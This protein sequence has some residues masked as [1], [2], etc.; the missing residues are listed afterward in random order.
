MFWG[1][2]PRITACFTELVQGLVVTTNARTQ[3]ATLSYADLLASNIRRQPLL[4]LKAP[5]AKIMKEQ[6]ELVAAYADLRGD[7]AAEIM[8][9]LAP[10]LPF[11]GSVIGI[12]P[13]RNKKTIQL[14]ELAFSLAVHVEMRFKHIFALTR[15][16]E[17]SAQIQP[18][19]STPEHGSWPSG[20]ATEAFIVAHVIEQLMRAAKPGHAH[21][22]GHKVL[23]EQLQRLASRIAVN[24]TVA[25]VHYPVDSAVGRMLGTV[26]GELFVARCQGGKIRE[27]GF[28]ALKFTHKGGEPMDFNVQEPLDSGAGSITGKGHAIGAADLMKWMWDEAKKEWA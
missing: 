17:W 26:L 9:Q 28:D 14:L 24:R 12:R 6:L 4:K 15:P 22:K 18:M 3:E 11:W 23:H 19:I 2:G 25:G 7:R 16:G 20:H 27:H 8:S 13:A 1:D 5:D 10:P 21:D